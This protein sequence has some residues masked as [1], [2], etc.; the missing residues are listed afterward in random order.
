MRK[1]RSPRAEESKAQRAREPHMATTCNG[2]SGVVIPEGGWS[3]CRSFGRSVVCQ[4]IL[5]QH[6][7]QLKGHLGDPNIVVSWVWYGLE[8]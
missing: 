5:V 3:S 2:G 4:K 6:K 8:N 7:R 1:A